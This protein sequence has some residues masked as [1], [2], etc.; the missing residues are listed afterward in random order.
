MAFSNIL[1]ATAVLADLKIDIRIPSNLSEVYNGILRQHFEDSEI[2]T[3]ASNTVYGRYVAQPHKVYVLS[4][5]NY[6]YKKLFTKQ[7]WDFDY[8]TVFQYDNMPLSYRRSIERNNRIDAL[9]DEMKSISKIRQLRAMVKTKSDL[10]SGFNV[11]LLLEMAEELNRKKLFSG[12][13]VQNL[14][15]TLFHR[16]EIPV[17]KHLDQPECAEALVVGTGSGTDTMYYYNSSQ[18]KCEEFVYLGTGGNGNSFKTL[19]LCETK[20]KST[21]AP[22]EKVITYKKTFEE[23]T[24]IVTEVTPASTVCAVAYAKNHYMGANVR[25]FASAKLQENSVFFPKITPQSVYTRP[26]CVISFHDDVQAQSVLSVVPSSEPKFVW[27]NTVAEVCTDLGFW[28][29]KSCEY[30]LVKTPGIANVKT[31]KVV[32]T[33]VLVKKKDAQFRCE[34]FPTYKKKVETFLKPVYTQ[35]V[36]YYKKIQVK[37]P[38]MVVNFFG[39]GD[40]GDIECNGSKYT[41]PAGRWLSVNVAQKAEVVVKTMLAKNGRILVSGGSQFKNLKFKNHGKRCR[42]IDC[43][44][45][46]SGVLPFDETFR[47]NVNY[48]RVVN[49]AAIGTAFTSE[50]HHLAFLDTE[51]PEDIGEGE[52]D[53]NDDD[54]DNED[55]L[56]DEEEL[57]N[58]SYL[59][60]FIAVF[61]F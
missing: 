41:V 39:Y 21:G 20:C 31:T 10:V 11:S 42:E 6:P 22:D 29:R 23:A 16:P 60:S 27:R 13:N 40:G 53:D 15:R 24:R 47:F 19:E 52:Y 5:S 12:P 9:I 2:H 34:C 35:Q 51:D 61:L 28:N 44:P 58:T 17:I 32:K 48:T 45:L 56:K 46:S 8:T 3:V 4:G 18:E 57:S 38:E 14:Y 43:T 54:N 50:S 1:L 25:I 59:I 33:E 36:K 7:E 26:N 30:R 55:D 37:D 49:L